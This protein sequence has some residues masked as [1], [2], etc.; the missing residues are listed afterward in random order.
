M[1]YNGITTAGIADRWAL[2]STDSVNNSSSVWI[3]GVPE[4]VS[5]GVA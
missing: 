5:K 2:I 4:R 3:T 1:H